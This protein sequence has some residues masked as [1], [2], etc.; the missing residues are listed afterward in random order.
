[1]VDPARSKGR[2]HRIKAGMLAAEAIYKSLKGG[3]PLE[4]YEQAIENSSVGKELYQ[5][6]NV[7][8]PF[9]RG[10]IQGAPISGLAIVSKG[11]F[12]PGRMEW[13]KNDEEPMFVG[14]TQDRYVK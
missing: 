10:F 6:R 14:D 3:E 1:M 4:S 13:H 8:Q 7:R 9:S 12:P 2:P 11:K 5:V